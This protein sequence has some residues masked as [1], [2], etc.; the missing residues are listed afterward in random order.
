LLKHRFPPIT[1]SLAQGAD[2]LSQNEEQQNRR[3]SNQKVSG[4]NGS[5]EKLALEKRR[6]WIALPW[7]AA[8]L[9]KSLFVSAQL[10]LTGENGAGRQRKCAQLSGMA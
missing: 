3:R 5:G 2:I 10:A 7:R 8:S 4:G 9:A 6:I 1:L